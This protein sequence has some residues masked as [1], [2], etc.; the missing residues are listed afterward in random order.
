MSITEP[1]H[2]VSPLM[3]LVRIQSL[4]LSNVMLMVLM[5]DGVCGSFT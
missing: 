4:L 2:I 5:S 3:Q 1:Q